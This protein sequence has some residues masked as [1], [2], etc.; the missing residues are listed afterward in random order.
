MWYRTGAELV[1]IVHLL[2]IGFVAGGAFLTW[3][4][5]RVAWAHIPV[6]V[7]GALVEFAGLTCPLTVVENDLRLSAGEAGYSGGFLNHYLIK[8][9]Y[10]PGLT[11]GMQIGLGVL[12]LLLAFIGYWGL[13][14][15]LGGVRAWRQT[16]PLGVRPEHRH[17]RGHRPTGHSPRTP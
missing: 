1:V 16:W 11:H 5:P 3:L 14:R 15:R 4:W 8:V 12:V 13:L 7:Y 6:V 17:V 10:P 2:F 9:I